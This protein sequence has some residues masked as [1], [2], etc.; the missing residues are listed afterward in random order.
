VLTEEVSWGPLDSAAPSWSPGSPRDGMGTSSEVAHFILYSPFKILFLMIFKTD[1]KLF[2][3]ERVMGGSPALP[4]LV[5]QGQNGAGTPSP[6][7]SS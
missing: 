3:Q 1:M 5:I 7:T 2:E 6:V 4:M